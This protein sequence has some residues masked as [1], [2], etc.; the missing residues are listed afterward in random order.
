[1]KVAAISGLEAEARIARG[2]GLTAIA[3]GGIAERTLA[4]AEA[5]LAEGADALASFGIAGALAP[6][7]SAGSLLLPRCVVDESGGR[8]SVDEA[9]RARVAAML[10]AAGMR[11]EEGDILGAAEAVASPL[12]K[13]E[14]CQKTGAI[15]VDLES[16][17][18]ARAA[19]RVHRPFIVLRAVADP[20]SRALPPAAVHGIDEKGAPALGRVLASVLRDPKQIPALVQLALDTRKALFALRSALK[21]GS[22]ANGPMGEAAP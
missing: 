1:M 9:W 8:Y 21:A 4:F 18:V 11:A 7:L 14:L 19:V 6:H 5:C 17:L 13:A 16:H 15:A 12:H 10:V 20:A 3:S 22:I 2:A